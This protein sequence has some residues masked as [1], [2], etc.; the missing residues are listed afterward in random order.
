MVLNVVAVRERIVF[1]HFTFA[2][3]IS[4]C[5]LCAA[6]NGSVTKKNKTY[7]KNPMIFPTFHSKGGGVKAR[8]INKLPEH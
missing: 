2:S 5:R 1:I 3:I 8:I 6:K 4:V 7:R